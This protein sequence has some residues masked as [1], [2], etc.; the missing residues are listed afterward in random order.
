MNILLCLSQ[1]EVTGAETYA[2]SVADELIKRGNKVFIASD[3]LT[4][5][6]DATFFCIKF[7]KRNLF[8]RI[9]N[10]IKLIKIIKKYKINIINSNS[11]A[12]SWIAEIVSKI[13]HIPHIVT[14]HGRQ[15]KKSISRLI[16]KTFGDKTIVVNEEL[17][18]H[19]IKDFYVKE[20]QIIT[21]R[22]GINIE[23]FSKYFLEENHNE[24]L[25]TEKKKI[26]IIGRLSGYK[27]FIIKRVLEKIIDFSKYEVFILGGRE[28]DKNIISDFLEKVKFI[29]YVENIEK[30]IF[31]SDFVIA[32]GRSAIEAIFMK[33]PVFVIGEEYCFGHLTE[34]NIYKA[35][36]ANF[37]DF[38]CDSKKD[39][40]KKFD[41]N[42]DWE[43]IKI[44]FEK[45][46]FGMS[47]L[48]KTDLY[49][50][51]MF[52]ICEK[53]FD[54]KIITE[55]LEKIYEHEIVKKKRYEIPVLMYHRVICDENDKGKHGIYVTKEQ[56]IKHLKILK[57]RNFI[58]ITFKD[59]DKIGV[60]NRFDKK[61]IIITFD[62]GYYD[63]Y[64]NVFPLIK[65]YDIKIVIY[66]TNENYNKWDTENYTANILGKEKKFNLLSK[67]QIKEMQASFLVEFGGHTKTHHSLRNLSFHD[68]EYEITEN[69]KY[70]ENILGEKL[71]S[72]SYPFGEF[73]ENSE[74]ILKN[75]GY[76]FAVTTNYSGFCLSDNIFK[77][78]RIA[79][80]PKTNIL[81][82]LRKIKGNYIFKRIK[83]N[84]EKII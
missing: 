79:V 62:D 48:K 71:I 1:L 67:E 19:L 13:L 84:K 28:K 14:V 44:D 10:I 45:F 7:N 78:R 5:K 29:G 27:G 2:V 31:S 36:S 12:S 69:K 55:K 39:K 30:Y 82:F 83:R 32:S 63:N 66:L 42:F 59:L 21:L 64:T 33:K 61:Y 56:F 60:N 57:S 18:K 11:R 65:K 23:R 80:M 68:E 37:G 77:I 17:E 73:T 6:T 16:F 75:L 3:T 25:N 47:N 22:N 51:K 53:E 40:K 4:T 24:N 46:I 50:E 43:K 26:C 15:S 9:T 20:N 81:G 52:N 74:K 58:P 35:I 70:L 72:F 8:Y 76:K 41:V 49:F 54:I 38:S 34:E